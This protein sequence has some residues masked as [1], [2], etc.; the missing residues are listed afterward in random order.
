MKEDV[1]LLIA[2]VGS[3]Q[4]VEKNVGGFLAKGEIASHPAQMPWWW[5]ANLSPFT[6]K[7]RNI[8]LQHFEMTQQKLSQRI[9]PL[10]F[11][12]HR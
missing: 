4:S 5:E 10:S 11:S 1:S 3:S 8:F 9:Q 6:K 12:H 7:P 2:F